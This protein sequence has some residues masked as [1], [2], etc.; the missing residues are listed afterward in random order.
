MVLTIYS[1]PIITFRFRASP[2]IGFAIILKNSALPVD[3]TI[4]MIMKINLYS[5]IKSVARPID[6][7]PGM[8]NAYSCLQMM[9]RFFRTLKQ[10]KIL[11]N[12]NVS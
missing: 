8:S 1:L 9:Q 7:V 11:S 4:I 2:H 3:L 6:T 10:I 12:Y 5:A